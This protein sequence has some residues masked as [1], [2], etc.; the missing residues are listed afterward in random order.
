MQ[1]N[2]PLLQ[3]VSSDALRLFPT[4][5]A[6]SVM[7]FALFISIRTL[8]PQNCFLA[9]IRNKLEAKSQLN[10]DSGSVEVGARSLSTNLVSIDSMKA[11][12]MLE[13]KGVP[14]CQ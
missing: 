1:N 11:K 13:Q 12:N 8:R 10:M 3:L 4:E 14:L 5:S 6:L 7:N 9:L 2:S